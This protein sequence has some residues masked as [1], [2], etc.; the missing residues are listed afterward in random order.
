[1]FAL[2]AIL[3]RLAHVAT[4]TPMPHRLLVLAKE[5]RKAGTSWYAIRTEWD[6]DPG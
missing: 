1:M 2:E 6:P 4:L 3:D 5:N